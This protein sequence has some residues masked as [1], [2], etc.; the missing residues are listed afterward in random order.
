MGEEVYGRGNFDRDSDEREC[1]G[2]H[3]R[4]RLIE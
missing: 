3:K 1:N 4:L 2:A